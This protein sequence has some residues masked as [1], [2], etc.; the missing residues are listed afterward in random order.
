[1]DEMKINSKFLRNLIAK[2]VKREVK[3]KAGYEVEDRK[4][5]V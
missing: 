1:M 2:F 3:K 4:S 5:V